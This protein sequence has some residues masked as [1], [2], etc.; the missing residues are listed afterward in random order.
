MFCV[1]DDALNKAIKAMRQQKEDEQKARDCYAAEKAR[2]E[3]IINQLQGRIGE[4][5]GQVILA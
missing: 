1:P 5:E 2:L 3:G 4:L